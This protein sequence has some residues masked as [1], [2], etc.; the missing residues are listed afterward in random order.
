L[1]LLQDTIIRD[2][3]DFIVAVVNTDPPENQTFAML[4]FYVKQKECVV[5]D[6]DWCLNMPTGKSRRDK[7]PLIRTSVLGTCRVR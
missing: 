3:Q 4:V 7:I 6:P 5:F 1:T 2:R